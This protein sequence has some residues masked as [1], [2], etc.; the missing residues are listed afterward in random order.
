MFRGVV[1]QQITVYEK[2]GAQVTEVKD[3]LAFSDKEI[4]LVVG[5]NGRRLVLGGEKLKISDFSKQSGDLSVDGEVAFFRYV[6]AK[7]SFWKRIF[8]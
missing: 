3:V 5:Q 6:G 1:M 2:K 7:E 4:K 8:K